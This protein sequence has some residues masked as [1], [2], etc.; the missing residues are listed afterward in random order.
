MR[1]AYILVILVAAC[2]FTPG[3]GPP[4]SGPLPLDGDAAPDDGPTTDAAVQQVSVA[5]S[6][7]VDDALQDPPPGAVLVAYAWMS[8]YTTDHWGA[9]R[10]AVPQVQ[11]GA[12]IVDAYLDVYLDTGSTEDDP[13]VAITSEATADATPLASVNNNISNRPRGA[14]RV[15][16]TATNL[17]SGMRRSPSLASVV[18]ERVDDPAWAPGHRIMF[19]FDTLGP[20]F[21]M[22]QYDF[23]PA[24]MYAPVLTVRFTNP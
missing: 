12:V 15:T 1:A 4:D 2:R 7:S 3:A 6:A 10:F 23:A 13:N 16:W 8:L 5:I 9:M 20:S 19:I 21:E 11:R 17:G 24:G 14:A 22:R 18:Q